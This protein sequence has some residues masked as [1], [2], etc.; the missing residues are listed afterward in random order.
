MTEYM[1]TPAS[2]G[3]CGVMGH[4]RRSCLVARL[5]REGEQI[6]SP[7]TQEEEA[8]V[9]AELRRKFQESP[10]GI[11]WATHQREQAQRRERL[12]R[13]RERERNLALQ[14]NRE[15]YHRA[16]ERHSAFQAERDRLDA[17][18]TPGPLVFSDISHSFQQIVSWARRAERESRTQ[19]PKSISLKMVSDFQQNYTV[20]TECSI[21]YNRMPNIGLPCK[22]TFCGDCTVKFAKK[23]QNCPL[24]RS[25]FQ[26]VHFCR[27]IEPEEFNNISAKLFL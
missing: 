22:H 10:L 17:I 27:N 7:L 13:E 24:C 6:R 25:I 9:K 11:R 26:E 8:R 14:R 4:N 5:R 1:R 12:R 20:E 21:C 2:C 19:I 3:I 18:A 23:S 15:A 16:Q